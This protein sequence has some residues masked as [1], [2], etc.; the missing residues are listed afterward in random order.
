MG[1]WKST[2]SGALVAVPGAA[3]IAVAHYSGITVT[4]TVAQLTARLHDVGW[5]W[6]ADITLTCWQFLLRTLATLVLVLFSISARRRAKKRL[7]RPSKAIAATLSR[8]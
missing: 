2:T 1:F 7:D 8:G 6:T 5:S 4:K 3:A